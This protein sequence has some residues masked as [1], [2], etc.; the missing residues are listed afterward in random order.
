[1]PRRMRRAPRRLPP[2]TRPR[3]ASFRHALRDAGRT[4][5]WIRSRA[6]KT[7]PCLAFRAG[8]ER[9]KSVRRQSASSNICHG[10][11][12][13]LSQPVTG[14]T[15]NGAENSRNTGKACSRLS[16]CPSSSVIATNFRGS[17]NRSGT[18][19]SGTI[20]SPAR[21]RNWRKPL[22]C[23]TVTAFPRL[24]VRASSGST[25]W[26]ARMAPAPE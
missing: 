18:V 8:E 6:S 16:R 15:E 23:D 24:S 7:R 14:K 25:R 10:T 21:R 12:L 17:L 9:M 2:E 22:S 4:Q 19:E 13:R 26:K 1:M 5:S 11:I 3:P 20:S